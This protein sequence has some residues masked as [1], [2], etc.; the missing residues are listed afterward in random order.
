MQ[1]LKSTQDSER[2][3]AILHGTPRVSG[4]DKGSQVAASSNSKHNRQSHPPIPA[5]HPHSQIK[6]ETQ[7]PRK[8]K[9][10]HQT[11][12]GKKRKAESSLAQR[13]AQ[14]RR[15]D[16]RAARPELKDEAYVRRTMH[17][18]TPQDYPDVSPT[19]FKS[20][21]ASL[22]NAV[23][24]LGELRFDVKTLADDAFQSTLHYKSAAHEA[25]VIGE[26]RSK[27][28][29]LNFLTVNVLTF[30]SQLPIMLLV[31]I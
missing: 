12:N 2:T 27:V 9:Q 5:S 8:K 10:E 23:H 28:S 1:E 6:Q 24:G 22:H 20:I 14:R 16:Q 7:S 29:E 15:G 3:S 25:V 17:I 31:C 26:G 4:S 30:N 11:V 13:P 19:F 18:P 21:K